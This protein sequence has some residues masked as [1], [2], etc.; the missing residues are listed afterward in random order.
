MN[1]LDTLIN[2]FCTHKT[3]IV[4]TQGDILLRAF[5]KEHRNELSDIEDY[6]RNY[7][8]VLECARRIDKFVETY[9]D[10]KTQ[11]SESI[12]LLRTLID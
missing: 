11:V 9:T 4:A 12:R 5:G 3:E 6:D 8:L 10:E 1:T 7:N 2:V